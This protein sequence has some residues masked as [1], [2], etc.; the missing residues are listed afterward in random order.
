L[1]E[2]FYFRQGFASCGGVRDAC[3]FQTVG[4][5]PCVWGGTM[6]TMRTAC[7]GSHYESGVMCA[8]RAVSKP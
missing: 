2:G 6:R 4:L 8:A 3:G 5:Y 1:V 7:A